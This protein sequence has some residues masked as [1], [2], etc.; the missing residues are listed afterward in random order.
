[1]YSTK[2][3]PDVRA[4]ADVRECADE[5]I[6]L[7]IPDEIYIFLPVGSELIFLRVLIVRAH[8]LDHIRSAAAELHG[9]VTYGESSTKQLKFSHGVTKVPICAGKGGMRGRKRR[10]KNIDMLVR[11]A[12]KTSSHAVY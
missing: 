12:K 7:R 3:C 10:F 2:V 4:C 9:I 1:M 5:Q 11:T 6:T 8:L